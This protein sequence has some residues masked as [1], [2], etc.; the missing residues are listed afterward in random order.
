MKLLAFVKERFH[1]AVEIDILGIFGRYRDVTNLATPK[2]SSGA[3][4]SGANDVI[5]I[6]RVLCLSHVFLHPLGWLV[7]LSSQLTFHS[8]LVTGGRH[9]LSG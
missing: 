1:N 6:D 5:A 7:C 9:N 4:S 3:N 8:H 2:N